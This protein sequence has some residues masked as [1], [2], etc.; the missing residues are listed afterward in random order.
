MV[1]RMARPFEIL[2]VYFYRQR[3]PADVRER[4]GP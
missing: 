1:V 4:V 2:G 3:G